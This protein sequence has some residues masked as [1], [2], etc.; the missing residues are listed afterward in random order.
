ML[1]SA[2]HSA[3]TTSIYNT[4]LQTKVLA[5]PDSFRN[6]SYFIW[7]SIE[8]DIGILAA[9]LPTLR[10]LFAR[11]IENTRDFISSGGSRD[12][13]SASNRNPGTSGYY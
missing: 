10:P 3:Y 1:T 11:I 5:D 12:K 9:S 8:F 2:F 13:S 7:N 6:D 4:I